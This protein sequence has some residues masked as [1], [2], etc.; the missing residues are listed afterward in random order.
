MTKQERIDD[1]VHK[2][3]NKEHI[4]YEQAEQLAITREFIKMVEG[5]SIMIYDNTQT[6]L[7]QTAHDILDGSKPENTVPTEEEIDQVVEY[8]RM[9]NESKAYAKYLTPLIEKHGAKW[10]DAVVYAV[11]SNMLSG[12]IKEKDNE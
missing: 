7:N 8:F 5:E 1:F 6:I 9:K 3:A 11:M 2:I 4:T 10:V 12:T